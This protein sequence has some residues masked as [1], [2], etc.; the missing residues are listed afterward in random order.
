MKS[1]LIG[2]T[3]FVGS[4]LL[5]QHKFSDKYNSSNIE[6]IEGK[7]YDLVVS[8][9]TKA[10]MWRINQEGDKDL[11]E[12]KSLISHFKKVKAK[13]F[14]LISTVGVYS[15]FIGV[16]EDTKIN[17]SEL[18]PYG[19][20]RYVLEE[21]IRGSF[22]SHIIRLPGLFGPGLKKNVIFDLLNNNN[23]DRIHRSSTY[24][25]YNLQNIWRDLNTVLKNDIK[26]I[27]FATEPLVTEELAKKCFDIEFTN[28]PEGTNPAK[29]DMQTK[30]ASSFGKSGK[31]IYNKNEEIKDISTFVKNYRLSQ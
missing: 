15:N 17:P 16:D 29:F 9:A 10:D 14:V 23:V 27:N 18:L 13:Q 2:Y 19:A 30:Y 21:F 20:N 5:S 4:N 31:Y 1:A 28:E 8:A 25:Y 6:E 26:L 22:D 7:S 11:A 24:Q 12:I 3:G